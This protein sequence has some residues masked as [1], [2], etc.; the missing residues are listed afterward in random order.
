MTVP[1]RIHD[2]D[3]LG[4]SPI[5]LRF[6]QIHR[7]ANP[8]WFPLLPFEC[9]CGPRPARI[10]HDHDEVGLAPRQI[11]QLVTGTLLADDLECAPAASV[12]G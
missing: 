1:A 8:G 10:R 11:R 9:D 6:S 4:L 2:C 7:L 12:T 3:D 5:R